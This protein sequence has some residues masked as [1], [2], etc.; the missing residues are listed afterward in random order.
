MPVRKRGRADLDDNMSIMSAAIPESAVGHTVSTDFI[1]EDVIKNYDLDVAFIKVKIDGKPAI[2]VVGPSKASFFGTASKINI[3]GSDWA[4]LEIEEIS[5][6]I[7]GKPA[8]EISNVS[9]KLFAFETASSTGRQ[10][11]NMAGPMTVMIGK[12]VPK[13]TL[14]R[15]LHRNL[16]N[17][18]NKLFKYLHV[19]QCC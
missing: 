17:N 4:E 1:D 11:W 9:K 8:T 18:A 14:C 5:I 15:R 13:S 19:R 6:K 12:R 10:P 2:Y 7:Q 3:F 16:R